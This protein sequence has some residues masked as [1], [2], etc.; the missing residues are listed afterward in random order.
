MVAPEWRDVRVTRKQ[1]R[2]MAEAIF[3]LEQSC[4]QAYAIAEMKYQP[5]VKSQLAL[6]EIRR[7]LYVAARW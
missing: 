3:W 1:A 6:A 4:I 7:R 5:S 2:A